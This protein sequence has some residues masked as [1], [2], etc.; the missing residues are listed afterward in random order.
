LSQW[1]R[2]IA[3]MNQSADSAYNANVTEIIG[4]DLAKNGSFIGPTGVDLAKSA[5]LDGGKI[6]GGDAGMDGGMGMGMG[7]GGMGGMPGM[8]DGGGMMPGGENDGEDDSGGSGGDSSGGG[9]AGTSEGDEATASEDPGDLRYVD[10]DY[11]PLP[12][13]ELRT[14][15][16]VTAQTS[17]VRHELAIAKRYPTRIRI[18]IDIRSLTQ[19]LAACGNAD[20]SIEVLQV[21]INAPSGMN[22]GG[23]AGGDMG[24]MGGMGGMTGGMDGG[25]DGGDMGGMPGTGGMGGMPGMGGMGGMPGMGGGF[26]SQNIVQS[27]RMRYHVEV[28]IYGIVQIYNPVNIEAL[29]IEPVVNNNAAPGGFGAE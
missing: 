24:D 15:L 9:T 11:A 5:L 25:D 27:D 19:F 13:A 10:A 29:G 26:G 20:L 14:A 28:E 3:E 6:S 17:N 7:M 22:K 2:I 16:D 12:V 21:R 4:I 8:G 1:L 23:S 18:K